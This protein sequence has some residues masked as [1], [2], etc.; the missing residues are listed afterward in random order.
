MPITPDQQ[1]LQ[2]FLADMQSIKQTMDRILGDVQRTIAS[3]DH[4]QSLADAYQAA[5]AAG[6]IP[7]SKRA[8][9]GAMLA[10]DQVRSYLADCHALEAALVVFR[11]A[12]QGE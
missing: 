9:V 5:V 7:E 4:L 10:D 2:K 12:H 3:V 11:D 8:L 6:E 1:A